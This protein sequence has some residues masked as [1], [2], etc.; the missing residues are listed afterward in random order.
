MLNAGLSWRLFFYIEIAFAGALLIVAF[1]VVEETT[2]HRIPPQS[3]ELSSGIHS[4]SEGEKETATAEERSEPTRMIPK[5]KTFLQTLKFW[6]VW[7]KD[8]EF[9]MMIAR[10][11]TY[12]LVPSVLWVVTTYGMLLQSHRLVGSS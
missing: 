5:R 6:G 8:S 11:F 3:Q 12:F 2:Y 7:E 4:H 1:F 10:S 9:F